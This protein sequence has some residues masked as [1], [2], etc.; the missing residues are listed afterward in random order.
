MLLRGV[1]EAVLVVGANRPHDPGAFCEA[2]DLGPFSAVVT[3]AAT[4]P[5]AMPAT[6]VADAVAAAIAAAG[7]GALR[8]EI[9]PA[10]DV[11]AAVEVAQDRAGPEGIVVVTGSLYIAAEARRLLVTRSH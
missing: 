10:A 3:A 1:G 2:L 5:R 6:E 7:L 4:W 9:I 11:S 8:P